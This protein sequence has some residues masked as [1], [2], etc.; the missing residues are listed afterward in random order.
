MRRRGIGLAVLLVVG[1]LASVTAPPAGGATERASTVVCPTPERG[2]AAVVQVAYV[3]LL[4]RCP[5]PAGFTAWTTALDDGLTAETFARRIAFT[6]EARGVIVNDAYQ[7]MLDR[8]PI[9]GDRQ[10]WVQWLEPRPGTQRRHDHL[11]AQLASSHEFWVRAGSTNGGFVDQVYERILRRPSDPAGRAYW[12]ARLDAGEPRWT[13]VLTLAQLDEPLGVTVSAVH[14]EILDRA[15]VPAERT[16]Y[17]R[18][19]RADGSR[20]WLAA[21]FIGTYE[22]Y[23]R[24]QR[25]AGGEGRYVS[26]GDSYV[27]GEGNPPYELRVVASPP[28]LPPGVEVPPTVQPHPCHRSTGSYAEAARVQSNSVPAHLDLAACS[29][30]QLLGAYGQLGA[31]AGGDDPD[32]VT[33]TIGGN[34]MGFVPIIEACLQ[35]EVNGGQVSPFYDAADCNT[36]LDQRAPNALDQLRNGLRTSGGQLRD[37]GGAPCTVAGLLD[38][39]A[40][41]APDARIAVVGYPPLLPPGSG[42]CSGPV[43]WDDGRPF[44]GAR[45]RFAGTY[46]PRGRALITALNDVLADAADDAGVT[47][48]DPAPQFAGHHVCSP[49]PYIYGL[50]LSESSGIDTASFHPTRAGGRAV[51]EALVEALQP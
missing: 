9:P 15:P 46:V 3:A 47:Y 12:V 41:A 26:I 49:D 24:A 7:Q 13:L 30:A 14:R 1:A 10:W 19:Y 21:R 28:D 17:T 23:Q 40:E 5:E 16:H 37:C 48:V 33:V 51:G 36:W 34:D 42:D 20:S 11:L 32:L 22:F 6:P 31:L 27:S 50:R 38:D 8:A 29:G 45:W 18:S 44:P 43:Q 35:V 39:I 4:R 25:A 2:H